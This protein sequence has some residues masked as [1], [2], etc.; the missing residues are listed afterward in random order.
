MISISEEQDQ[1]N[2][3][4]EQKK[5]NAPYLKFSNVSAIWSPTEYI[6]TQTPIIK[7]IS[8][9]FAKCERVALIG[10]VGC[11]KSTL[12]NTILKEAYV[13][14][15]QVEVNSGPVLAA[16][17]E[18]NPL[19]ISGTVRSNI[20]Y[21]S[22]YD[23]EYYQKVITACQLLPDIE[24]FPSGDLTK[25]GEMG[26]TLSGGQRSRI[27]L[28]R[29]LY[30]RNANIIL[31]DGTLSSLDSR[32]SAEI[33]TQIKEGELFKNKLVI[34]VTYDLDQA[35]Q[36]DWVIHMSDTGSIEASM[37]SRDFFTQSDSQTLQNIK[38]MI[39]MSKEGDQNTLSTAINDDEDE[40][41]MD[42][43]LRLKEEEEKKNEA[44]K[45]DGKE[46]KQILKEEETQ[47]D[48][49]TYT[50]FFDYFSFCTKLLGGRCSVFVIII[51]HILINM[52]VSSLSLYLGITLQNG[53]AGSER[54][55]D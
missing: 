46:G 5:G 21:G 23:P 32:V 51:L 42:S 10:R 35:E 53:N 8:F 45:D 27:S 11:G 43:N 54:S 47:I 37:S 26:V 36:M 29:A 14:E 34:L 20:T 44:K 2:F 48:K 25:T 49:V 13:R 33:L 12:L 30:K 17:A 7:D 9:E 6:E 40:Q 4:H 55:L 19:I 38:Q 24:S 31:I 18:Q 50:A 52:S 41:Q 16:Y 39:K 1:A 28:A 22:K 15:G 3:K